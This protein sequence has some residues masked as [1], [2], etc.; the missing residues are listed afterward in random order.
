MKKLKVLLSFI[1]SCFIFITLFSCKSNII[2][3]S[4][5]NILF[6]TDVHCGVSDN[7]GYS[8]LSQYKNELLNNSKKVTLVD[9]GDAI[10]GDY[11]GAVSKGEYIIEIMNSLGYEMMTLGNHEF[12]YGMDILSQRIS[13]F[14]GDVLSCNINYVGKNSNKLSSVKPYKI[15]DYGNT[16]VGYLGVT[17][18]FTITDSTPANFM[19]DNEIVYTLGDLTK[20]EEFYQLIQ[21][22][23][24]ELK[25]SGCSY[26]VVLGHLG[27]G[28]E[29]KEFSSD[30]VIKN[31]K[32]IDVFL[33][34]H[35]HKEIP[36]DYYKNKEDKYIPLCSLEYKLKEFGRV[37]ISS[38]GL[39]QVG[40]IS[41]YSNKD[42]N[43]DNLLENINT[44]LEEL[45]NRVLATS[46]MELSTTDSDGIRI[47]RNQETAIGN[48]V[49]DAYRYAGN[50][51]IGFA[52]GG[53]I[54]DKIKSGDLTFKDMMSVNPF[55]NTICT[56][57][58][59]GSQIADY[60]EFASKSTELDYK[61][62]GKP[63]GESG[64]FAC[65]SGLKYTIDT[66]IE[67]SV[68]I[69]EKGFFNGVSGKRRVKDILVLEGDTYNPI[70]LEKKYLVS[71]INYILTNG[72]DGASMFMGNEVK[73]KDIMLDY[74]AIVNYIVDVLEGDLLSKYGTLEGRIT[75]I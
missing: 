53:G 40:V 55:G 9:C 60:L 22:N 10:Q 45:G 65:V 71:S 72:G 6:T 24:D 35:A 59:T 74:E 52:N 14:N 47:T 68:L 56:M 51:T 7:I 33:D 29:Y 2:D 32:G 58:A 63:I 13:E 1:I 50:A 19:E 20:P 67:S 54:R 11:I 21:S 27:Y 15:I 70:D 16:K 12:D 3:N 4:E 62:G 31:T 66:S 25:N 64:A 44:K 42:S 49:A 48:F 26:V 38:D 73:T 28:S 61:S 30:E 41:N 23:V 17:T 75:K 43:C 18:P 34:G 57:E 39:I 5:I 69:D 36:C 46:N 37:T 8:A